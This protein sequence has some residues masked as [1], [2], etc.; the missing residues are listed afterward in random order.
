MLFLFSI[1]KLKAFDENTLKEHCLNLE[2][3]LKLDDSWD[4]D[5][6]DLFHEVKLLRYILHLE[7]DTVINIVNYIKKFSFFF[8]MHMLPIG[9]C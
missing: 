6:L 2:K 9:L 8:Q 3:S 7:R 5:G 4:I 1:E